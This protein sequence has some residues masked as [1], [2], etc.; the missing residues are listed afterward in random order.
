MR[1][2]V[3]SDVHGNVDALARAG[4]G[5]DALLVLGDL[6]DFV[7]YHDP[8]AGILGSVFGSAAV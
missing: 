4:A 2:H 5:A 7:N 3:V 6:I 1:V 8:S